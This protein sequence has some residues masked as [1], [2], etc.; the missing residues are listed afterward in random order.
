MSSLV[1]AGARNLAAWHASS[2]D[3]LGLD[4]RTGDRWW[5]AVLPGPT[6]YHSAIA[7]AP[8][9]ASRWSHRRHLRDVRALFAEDEAVY[10]S[11]CDSW[12]ELDLEPLGLQRHAV[13]P[14]FACRPGAAS[15]ADPNERADGRLELAFV[16]ERAELLEFEQTMARA[17]EVPVLI[18]PFGVHAP[19]VL[20]DPDMYV[21][22]G[23]LDGEP[24]T[25]AMAYR[26][27]GVLGIYG[28]GTVPEHRGAG[29]ALEEDPHP[30]PRRI[31]RETAST[32]CRASG[33]RTASAPPMVVATRSPLSRSAATKRSYRRCA[34]SGLAAVSNEGRRPRRVEEAR[35]N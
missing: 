12:N 35:V 20:D 32:N 9:S 27:G 10:R 34:E 30:R 17:F 18:P 3:A 26:A 33:T 8:R 4:N 7:L 23:R 19:P 31:R 13:S 25:V 24:V 11:V 21:L 6:I 29:H 16:T 5:T 2:V 28:V 22:V 14:W 15:T 1:A